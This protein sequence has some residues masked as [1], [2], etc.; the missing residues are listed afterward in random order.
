MKKVIC[1]ALCVILALTAS[2]A[3]FAAQK[4]V[5]SETVYV[6][7]ESSGKVKEIISSVYIT[8]PDKLATLTDLASLTEI[9]NIGGSEPPAVS[10]NAI[11]FKTEGDDVVYQGKANLPLPLEVDIQYW[12]N[13]KKLSAE[14]L[15]GQS[16]NVK[17]QVTVKN[18]L[19]KLVDV[20]GEQVKMYT[21]FTAVAMLTLNERFTGVT[22]TGAKVASEAGG[23]T[24]TG[25]LF[26]GLADSLALE[27]KDKLVESFTVQ[28][29]VKNF[30]LDS[31]S[32]IAVNGI[33][34]ES[35]LEGVDD[36]TELTDGL[37]ELR[38]GV[39]ELEDGAKQL[40]DGVEEYALGVET[41]SRAAR[42]VSDGMQQTHIGTTQ[43][44]SGTAKLTSGVN[45]LVSGAHK[46]NSGASELASGIKTFSSQLTTKL[47]AYLASMPTQAQLVAAVQAGI[48]AGGETDPT[49]IAALTA[50]VMQQLGTVLPSGTLDVSAL[51]DALNKLQTGADSLASGTNDLSG[52]T[53]ELMDGVITLHKGVKELNDGMGKLVDGSVQL[54]DGTDDLFDGANEIYDGADELRRGLR[55][56]NEEGLD[57][58]I[59]ET[60]DI[61]VSVS[62]KDKLLSLSEEYNTYSGVDKSGGDVKFVYSTPDIFVQSQIA[63]G[64]SQPQL[65]QS[66]Q[67]ADEPQVGFFEGVWNWI[68]DLFT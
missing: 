66:V 15:A 9:K 61:T 64:T 55:K 38:D 43:L 34:S 17:I 39:G 6:D 36:I 22:V 24:I 44:V 3:A 62:R 47:N 50:A 67:A 18:K 1:A 52:G 49:K 58:M 40:R 59:S 19:E 7:M 41:F 21:P 25:T 28:A 5:R 65:P 27:K 51:T 26:P 45:D 57:E 2:T 16:G 31:I 10:G 20:D 48:V 23:T 8:N 68:V 53:E 12:L 30:E 60:S 29:S 35:D 56:L 11:T 37:N 42:Q 14:E 63:S 46:L 54:A 32:V 33:L 4:Q 13:G